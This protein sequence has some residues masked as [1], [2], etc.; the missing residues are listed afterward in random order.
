MPPGDDGGGDGDDEDPALLHAAVR[1]RARRGVGYG[2][3]ADPHEGDG[4]GDGGGVFGRGKRSARATARGSYAGCMDP[5]S[6]GWCARRVGWGAPM[7]RRG[8]TAR[9]GDGDGLLGY[10]TAVA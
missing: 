6:V 5:G 8:Q 10:G 7:H 1:W 3:N 2:R 4:D 9:M